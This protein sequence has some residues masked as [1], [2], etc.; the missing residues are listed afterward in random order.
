MANIDR[1]AYDAMINL[2]HYCRHQV[3][4]NN[5]MFKRNSGWASMS[6]KVGFPRGY[7]RITKKWLKK[8]KEG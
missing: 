1:E 2:Q 4:C 7:G 6:C 3:D 5:C 8:I